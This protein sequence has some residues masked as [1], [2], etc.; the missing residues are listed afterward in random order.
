[1]KNRRIEIRVSESELAALKAK[2]SS[3]GLSVSALLRQ[4]AARVQ[5]WTA[6]DRQ[7]ACEM[8]RQVA[9]IGNNLNQVARWC[10]RYKGRADTLQVIAHLIAIERELEKVQGG[11]GDAH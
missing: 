11:A 2:A 4:A 7:T 8:I 6:A 1:M 9:R 10:N 3:A 5:T